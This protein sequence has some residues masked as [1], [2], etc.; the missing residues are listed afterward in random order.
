MMLVAEGSCFAVPLRSKGFVIGVVAR[1][2]SS[3]GVVLAY[4]FKKIWER[5]P[6]LDE[7]KGLKPAEA[8]RILR[9]GDLELIRGNWPILGNLPR[10]CRSDWIMPQFIRKDELS[11]KAWS[12]QYSDSDANLVE[13]ETPIAYDTNLERDAVLGA[14]AVEIVLSK[15]E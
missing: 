4:F 1:N 5:I 14:G 12:V 2:S 6:F 7:I 3:S 13:R 10:W 9:I 8:S 11:R 15:Q